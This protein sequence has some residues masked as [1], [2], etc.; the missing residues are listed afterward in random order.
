MLSI[1]SSEI[2]HDFLLKKQ[3]QYGTKEAPHKVLEDIQEFSIL[4]RN[5][6]KERFICLLERMDRLLANMSQEKKS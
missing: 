4:V 6:L 3:A 2:I 1:V 5:H